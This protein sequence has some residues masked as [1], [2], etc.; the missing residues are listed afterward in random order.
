[1]I[2]HHIL[3]ITGV[4]SLSPLCCNWAAPLKASLFL[5]S[6]SQERSIYPGTINAECKPR[7]CVM[8]GSHPWAEASLQGHHGVGQKGQGVLEAKTSSNFQLHDPQP[9]P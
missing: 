4:N 5:P 3:T 7:P 1:M 6:T 2:N 9:I 8:E